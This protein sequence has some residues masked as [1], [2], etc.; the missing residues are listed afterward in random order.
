MTCTHC[1]YHIVLFENF[2]QSGTSNFAG[3]TA[4]M[5]CPKRRQDFESELVR[6]RHPKSEL[7]KQTESTH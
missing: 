5:N 2:T 3:A 4:Q 1:K 6:Y 7:I